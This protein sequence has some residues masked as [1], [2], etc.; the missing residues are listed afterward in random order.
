MEAY[1]H[2]TA[3]P[4]LLG[5]DPLHIERHARALYGYLGYG[6]SGVEARGNS[7][8]DIALWDIFGK[9]TGQPLYQL[10]GGPS[11]DRVPHL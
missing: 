10:L 9:V 6:S 8:V 11:R 1:L 5:T 2:E 7:A 4:L 3:A